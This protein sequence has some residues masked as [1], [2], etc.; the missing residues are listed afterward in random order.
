MMLF[1]LVTGFGMLACSAAAECPVAGDLEKGIRVTFDD[2]FVIEYR[3]REPGVIEE[4]EIDPDDGSIFYIVT[5]RGILE[6]ENYERIGGGKKVT[7]FYRSNMIS[8]RTLFS[9]WSRA[10]AMAASRSPMTRTAPGL[11]RFSCAIRWGPRG[12]L[13][14]AIAVMTRSTCS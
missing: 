9:R 6:I 3:A 5:E 1:K 7:D 11:K 12:P 4:G 13:R 10:R 14:L 8:T 2:G